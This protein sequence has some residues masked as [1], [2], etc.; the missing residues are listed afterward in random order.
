MKKVLIVGG[1]AAGMFASIVAAECGHEVHVFDRNEKFGKKLFITGKGRCNLTNHC[2]AEVFFQNVMRN[3]KFLYSSFYGFDAQAAVAFFERLGLETKI[4]RGNRVFPQSDHSSD[5]L[6]VLND[7]MRKRNVKMHLNTGVQEVMQEQGGF[8]GLRLENGMVVSGDVGIVATGGISYPATG[9]TGDGYRFAKSLGHEI[10]PCVPSLVSVRSEDTCL[11]GLQG[12]S[13]KNVRLAAVILGGKKEKTVY[14]ELGEMLFTHCGVSGPLVLSASAHLAD[15]LQQGKQ[16]E[17]R[18]DLKPGLSVEQLDARILRDFEE[19]KN[20]QFKNSLSKLLPQKLIQAVMTKSAIDP[21]KRIHLITKEERTNLIHTFKNFKISVASLGD[22]K[23]AV[24]TRGGVSVK[25]VNPS[26][27]ESKKI[28]GVY[29]IGEVLDI[30][31]LTGGYNLQI[32]WST[33]HAAGSNI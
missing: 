21:E 30:D 16:T 20:K 24:I 15:A 9:S 28:K 27:M 26:T 12:L 4:E 14:N 29:F 25:E 32:A 23:E 10:V 11:K 22:F 17:L 5:V 33:A 19:V 31:A 7:G 6:R 2:D 8:F 3:S 1:G 18:L 13:L